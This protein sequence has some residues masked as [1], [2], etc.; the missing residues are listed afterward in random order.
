[1]H[2]FIDIDTTMMAVVKLEV[3][4]P[5]KSLSPPIEYYKDNDVM[6]S[7]GRWTRFGLNI[8]DRYWPISA[9]IKTGRKNLPDLTMIC[10]FWG[11]S[12]SFRDCVESL[13]PNVHEFRNVDIL[14]NDQSRYEK[15]FYAMNIKNIVDDAVIWDQTTSLSMEVNGKRR[16]QAVLGMQ[17]YRVTMKQSKVDNKHIFVSHDMAR[18]AIAVSDDLHNLLRDRK[19]L[20]GL[21]SLRIDHG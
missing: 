16:L 6:H 19:L 11:V 18:G 8:P 15:N 14:R 3:F 1:M 13:E 9:T 4:P 20:S 21:Q 17:N 7:Y 10:M 5:C 12:Q 2:W